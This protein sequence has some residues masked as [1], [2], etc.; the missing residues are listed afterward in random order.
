M[1]RKRKPFLAIQHSSFSWMAESVSLL[2]PTSL[3]VGVEESAA[4]LNTAQMP[5]INLFFLNII[6]HVHTVVSHS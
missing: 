2:L 6:L 5:L 4:R 3:I 1:G